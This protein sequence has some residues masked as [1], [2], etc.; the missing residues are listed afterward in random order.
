MQISGE[1]P[2]GCQSFLD[3]VPYLLEI[4]DLLDPVLDFIDYPLNFFPYVI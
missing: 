1:F 2:K 4:L 3:M